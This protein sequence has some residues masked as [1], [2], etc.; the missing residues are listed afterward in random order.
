MAELKKQII[1]WFHGPQDY[2]QG[3]KL[4]Q[5]V[6]KKNKI[7]GKMLKKGNTKSSMEKLV[8]EL[9]KVAGLKKIPEP[10]TIVKKAFRPLAKQMPK[11]EKPEVSVEKKKDDEAGARFN[12]IG[13]NEI[14]SYPPV[15]QRLVRENSALYMLR[16][17]KHSALKK[18][19]E[20]N[21]QET[22]A[23]R[24]QLAGEI[25]D[26]SKRL[27]IL[28]E[29]FHLFDT[30]KALPD[31]NILWPAVKKE[32]QQKLSDN[33]DDL[34]LQKKNIQSSVT[35]DRNLLLYGSKI[36]P[37][38]GEGSAMPAGP[39]RTIIEKRVAKKEKEIAAI[40]QRIADLT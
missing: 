13:K 21:T 34:K 29:A 39:K 7:I 8:W 32:E 27:D 22:V 18:L 15:I 37:K 40:E 24:E 30:K 6:S 14:G 19:P 4:L 1:D 26:I 17:K 23:K 10:K 36:K 11:Q 28:F 31:E 33:I 3:M 38:E 20:D 2:D 5:A 35:K 16:G 9:N 25:K 12:L